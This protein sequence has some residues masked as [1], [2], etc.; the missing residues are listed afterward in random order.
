MCA[1]SENVSKDYSKQKKTFD[2]EC[3]VRERERNELDI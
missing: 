2:I 3:K 1:E